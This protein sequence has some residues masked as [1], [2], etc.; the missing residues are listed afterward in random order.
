MNHA[1]KHA[2][3][4]GAALAAALTWAGLLAGVAGCSAGPPLTSGKAP[5]DTIWVTPEDGSKGVRPEQR[6]EV[7]VPSGRLESVK[8]V[9][10]QDAQES[11]VPGRMSADGLTWRP[12]GSPKLALAARDRPSGVAEMRFSG[13]GATW[14]A[15]Q[16]FAPA[17]AYDLRG[18]GGGSTPGSK[19]V[20]A[21]VR[22]RAGNPS[23]RRE[24]SIVWL[25]R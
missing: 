13:D 3:R 8:V 24:A 5:G 16:P 15:W 11:R 23:E 7:R 10:S 19:R 2:R 14:S 17:L 18:N 4:A 6:F 21:E 12:T 25:A 1:Q 22:D 9:K 20:V